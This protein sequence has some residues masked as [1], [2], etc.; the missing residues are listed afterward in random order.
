MTL[1]PTFAPPCRALLLATLLGGCVS[2]EPAPDYKA[3]MTPSS[4]PSS[5]QSGESTPRPTTITALD[6]LAWAQRAPRDELLREHQRLASLERPAEALVDAVHLGILMSVSA[7]ASPDTE[8]QALALLAALDLRSVDEASREYS[9]LAGLLLH[10]LQQ[11]ADLRAATADVVESR[12]ALETLQ[13]TNRELQ[14]TID[15]LTRIEE[16]L[17]EREQAQEPE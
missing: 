16:Q 12:E 17:I 3:A 2:N 5:Q 11:R 1:T 4:A 9:T 15:A 8:R 10:H 6:Y 14:Q 7:L 13:R